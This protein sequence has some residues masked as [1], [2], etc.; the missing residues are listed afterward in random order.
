MRKGGPFG[1]RSR[2]DGPEFA[3]RLLDQSA[4]LNKVELGSSRP[5]EPTD[6]A[7]IEA[8]N[9]CLRQ[10]CLDASWF[11]SMADARA[12]ITEMVA[13]Y[14]QNRPPLSPRRLD[15]RRTS[16]RLWS[17]F[18]ATFRAGFSW[19]ANSAGIKPMHQVGPHQ[20]AGSALPPNMSNQMR[21]NLPY[22]RAPS[23]PKFLTTDKDRIR[24]Q[25]SGRGQYA[26]LACGRC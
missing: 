1:W 8:F 22:L 20:Q 11:L 4:Y 3:G 5:G 13:D 16:S 9:S 6:N 21:Q 24:D 26:Q 23:V 18:H 15:A 17:G 7:F 19:S 2:P 14:N 25:E 12:R 10:E